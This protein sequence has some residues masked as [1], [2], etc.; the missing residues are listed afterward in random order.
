LESETVTKRKRNKQKN[1]KSK[2]KP[3]RDIGSEKLCYFLLT[4]EMGSKSHYN[5]FAYRQ[6]GKILSEKLGFFAYK[7]KEEKILKERN[8]FFFVSRSKTYAKQI[9]FRQICTH[10][11]S[12]NGHTPYVDV[13][14][15]LGFWRVRL[16]HHQV[17]FLIKTKTYLTIWDTDKHYH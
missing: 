7:K 2:R 15:Q 10:G 12:I 11:W 13:K 9:S 6:N 16:G 8:T 3:E 17:F 5:F 4:S 1:E 14:Y